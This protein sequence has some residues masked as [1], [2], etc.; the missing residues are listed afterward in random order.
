MILDSEFRKGRGSVPDREASSVQPAVLG[1]S[2]A[3]GCR[4]EMFTRRCRPRR[5]LSRRRVWPR[6]SQKSAG[7][8]REKESLKKR[9]PSLP[10][11]TRSRALRADRRGERTTR[12]AGCACCRMRRGRRS[13]PGAVGRDGHRLVQAS[14]SRAGRGYST[15]RGRGTGA[16]RRSAAPCVQ[17]DHDCR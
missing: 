5:T 7:C 1:V 13:M 12:S 3:N 10:G 8:G 9:W 16:C 14:V 6:W 17:A 2:G 4:T 15:C 11:Q